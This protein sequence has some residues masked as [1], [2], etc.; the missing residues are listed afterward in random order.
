[1]LSL[2]FQNVCFASRSTAKLLTFTVRTSREVKTSGANQDL[3]LD[4]SKSEC[5]IKN[6]NF[7]YIKL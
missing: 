7:S 4:I 6:T 5:W 2:T 1:M 3:L